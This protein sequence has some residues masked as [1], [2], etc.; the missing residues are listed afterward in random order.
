VPGK[1]PTGIIGCG[2]Y[3]P[4]L[5][6][7]REEYQKAWGYFSPRWVE[8]KSV[9]DFDEDAITMGVEAASNAFRNTKLNASH[10]DAVYFASTTPPYAEKQNA[11]TLAA[12][13]GCE[14]ET[15]T[16]DVTSSI[17]CG[18]SALLGG[19]DF[20]SSD[21]GKTALIVG[22]DAPR[23]D[24]TGSLDHQLGA[25]AA[26]TIVGRDLINGII[27]GAFS[28]TSESLGERYRRGGESFV[29][30]TELG[31][32]QEASSDGIITSCVRG[33]MQRI[34]RTSK[35][36]DFL[37]LQGIDPARALDLAKRLGFEDAKASLGD[38]SRNIGD[39]GAA[40]PLL[41]LSRFLSLSSF[42]QRMLICS[43]GPGAGAD[44]L[45]IIVDGEMKPV[46]GIAFDDYLSRKEYI[47]Y[48]AY[49]KIRRFLGKA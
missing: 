36:Y 15:A 27:E 26:A 21:R 49:L 5:R 37:A 30:T 43:Y 40:A 4:R 11:S 35:D 48:Y 39:T 22:S 20:A 32:Y 33:L 41:T 31:R 19:L 25:G 24:P 46:A 47:D 17:N 3:I 2:V 12:A 28:V 18:L 42:K 1:L 23:A 7:K 14:S 44:A 29:A 16:L 34:D 45:S 8:E 6:I 9:A 10:V 13:L 38:V